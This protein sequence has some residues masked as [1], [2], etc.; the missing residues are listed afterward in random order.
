[1]LSEALR[2]IRV[3]HDMKQTEVA[4][5]LGV[6]KSYLSEIEKG[7]KRPTLDLLEKYSSNFSIPMSSILFFSESMEN[8]HSLKS[9]RLAV[10]GKI[11]N[12]M[13]FLEARSDRVD[14]D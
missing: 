11:V 6:S 10:A 2:L 14:A 7:R 4:E 5:K 9:A 3:F 13:K 8:N 12:F 1:M